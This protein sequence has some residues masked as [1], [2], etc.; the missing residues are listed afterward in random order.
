MPA[1]RVRNNRGEPNLSQIVFRQGGAGDLQQQRY[2]EF[3]QRSITSTRYVDENCLRDLG[4]L[5]TVQRLLDKLGLTKA[6]TL[7]LPTY[8]ALTLEFLSSY[9][10]N[11]PPGAG[12]HLTG[13]ANFRMF[14]TEY[15]VD[16]ETLSEI[17]QFTRG[18]DVNYRIPPEMD[19]TATSFAIWERIAGERPAGWDEL[20]ST[21]I[22]N[23]CIRYFHRILANTI[24]GRTNNN[25]VNSKEMFFFHCAFARNCRINASSFLMAHIQSLV[26]RDGTNVPFCI[27]GIVTSIALHLNL[28]DKLQNLPSLPAV[29]MDIDNCRAGHLIK[30][31]EEGGYNL[32]VRNR[33]VPSVIL[34][35]PAITRLTDRNNWLYDLDAPAPGANVQD[36]EGGAHIDEP[37][38]MEQGPPE[39]DQQPPAR[40]VASTSTRRRRRSDRAPATN[41]DIL[42]AIMQRNELDAQRD[43]R[44]QTQLT[45]MMNLM[46]QIQHELAN[47]G[48]QVTGVITELNALTLRVGDL[49]DYIHQVGIPDHHV[50]QNG[51][52][53]ARTPGRARGRG[54]EG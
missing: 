36:I 43:E 6:C 32:M 49:Q 24:F 25:R 41:D 35:N 4:M 2:R 22:H 19:W 5:D 7:N 39:E 33:K 34:P 30:V 51:R 1:R 16:Q 14:N 17:L 45:N 53:R 9:S 44:N 46:Q 21:H 15:T 40:Q 18:E 38:E 28:G 10:Y 11:T 13:A 8:E 29:F 42:A 54:N 12:M 48:E 50:A 20:L 23:P 31:R 37:D 52:G 3:Y 27:G 26:A 47:Q